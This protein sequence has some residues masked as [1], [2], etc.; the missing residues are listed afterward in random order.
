V[1]LYE[2]LT[3]TTPLDK[4]RLHAAS[5]DGLRRIIREEE[6][7]RLSARISTLAADRASTV[8]EHRRTDAR[9][10]RQTVCGELDWIVMKALEKDRRRRYETASEFA[11]DVQRHLDNEPVRACPP[12]TWYRLRKFTQRN[13]AALAT[14]SLIAAAVLLVVGG[15]GWAVRDRTARQAAAGEQAQAVLDEALLLVDQK[16]WPEAV[17]AV[18]RAEAYLAASGGSGNLEVELRE[19][20]KDVEMV[21]RLDEIRLNMATVFFNSETLATKDTYAKAFREYGIDVEA[22]EPREVAAG[23]RARTIRV[24]LALA[25][26]EWANNRRGYNQTYTPRLASSHSSQ[27]AAAVTS[28]PG[29]V[30]S[31]STD[32]SNFERKLVAVARAADPDPWRNRLRD[33][34]ERNENERKS[35]LMDL[36]G[37][38]QVN[39]LPA[40]TASLLALALNGSGATDQARAILGAAQ[41]RHPDD[42]WINLALAHSHWSLNHFDAAIAFYR[43]AL[44][45]RPQS[46]ALY[47]S[48]GPCSASGR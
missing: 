14:A 48:I 11:A 2:L 6:P 24:E 8:A 25:L 26:D 22:L 16:K 15:I 33:A 20:Q 27:I 36:A 31:H 17:A 18:K 39:N 23:I 13:K 32:R 40:S 5:Y 21:L 45:I 28:A 43:A 19:L 42:F 4:D 3:G 30:W 12:S 29:L 35:M 7:P 9:R 34:I 47:S 10:L 38:A 46:H 41:R 44:A 1:L 37:S